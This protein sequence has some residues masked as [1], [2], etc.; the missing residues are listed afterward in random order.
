MKK[1]SNEEMKMVILDRLNT[2]EF[3]HVYA[4]A[5]REDKMVKAVIVENADEIMPLITYCE[6]NSKSHGG[7][8]GVRMWNAREAFEVIKEYAREII[9][10][11]SVKE[12]ETIYAERKANGYSG[13]RGNLFEDMFADFTN[14]TQNENPTAKCTECGDVIVKGEHIQCKFWNA[15]VTTE[16]QVNR[17]YLKHLEKVA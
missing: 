12:F 4:F 17:F 16:P 14:G 1:N 11:C 5:I 9:P 10:M 15:T 3:T 7:V 6:R 8:W 2:V 13:N